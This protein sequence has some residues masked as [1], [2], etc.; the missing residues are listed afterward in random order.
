MP[1]NGGGEAREEAE[2]ISLRERG[3]SLVQGGGGRWRTEEGVRMDVGTYMH[4]PY[5][6]WASAF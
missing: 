6:S 3:C 4:S 2:A 1:W 5:C